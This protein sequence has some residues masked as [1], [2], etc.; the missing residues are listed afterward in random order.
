MKKI[1][2]TP[3]EC[4]W[5]SSAVYAQLND[6]A[7]ALGSQPHQELLSKGW[8]LAHFIS[9]KETEGGYQGAVYVHENNKEVVIAHGGTSFSR[10]GTLD[11]DWTA[12][13][14]G[15]LHTQ[16][17][18]ALTL[19]ITLNLRALLMEG[20]Y[21]LVFT[22][23]SLGGFLATLS[24]YFCQRQDLGYHFPDSCAVVFDPAG[25]QDVMLSLEPHA[26]AGAGIG[27][28]GIAQLDIMHFLSHPN[29]VNAFR[30][31]AGGTKYAL[32]SERMNT[33]ISGLENSPIT[34]LEKTHSLDNIL[35]AFNSHTGYPFAHCCRIATDWPLIDLTDAR[36]LGTLTGSL[37]VLSSLGTSLA[38]H[39][40]GTSQAVS[41]WRSILGGEEF[42]YA[43]LQTIREAQST[44]SA[45]TL[46]SSLQSR[47]IFLDADYRSILRL[48]HF[49][50]TMA[51]F[52]RHWM[53]FKGLSIANDFC[54]HHHL[55]STQR[56]FF[57]DIALDNENVVMQPEATI[58]IFE[59]R[60]KFYDL[61]K[62]KGPDVLQLQAY[63]IQRVSE[64]P[65]TIA[66]IRAQGLIDAERIEALEQWTREAP[67]LSAS[68]TVEPRQSINLFSALA[69]EIRSSATVDVHL[70]NTA[71]S[72][73]LSAGI[74]HFKTAPTAN[75]NYGCAIATAKDS[76]AGVKMTIGSAKKKAKVSI[77]DGSEEDDTK[78][79]S[80]TKKSMGGGMH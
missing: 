60:K 15:K 34:Y 18:D 37:S 50:K 54:E 24:L 63:V 2:V 22:G 1:I 80:L 11:A 52:L 47:R 64:L 21:T 44:S 10:L 79:E 6:E 36:S 58:S 65:Q 71:F 20:Q 25:S 59:W 73:S 35:L 40:T 66:T 7:I 51:N 17:T 16:I 69:P 12:V 53:L 26:R 78:A 19:S 3:L 49:D 28:E 70:N 27:E 56:Q 30:P 31:H 4:G 13:V 75:Y 41:E 32:T 9:G 46:R 33:E 43:A 77:A 55:T 68:S 72:E 8:R 61:I 14:Q 62:I 23:H 57:I 38:R 5:M 29:Y 39:L 74:T 45:T 48:N 67:Q 76:K 42:Q